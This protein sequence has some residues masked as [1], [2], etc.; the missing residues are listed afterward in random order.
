M[1]HFGTAFEQAMEDSPGHPWQSPPVGIS[2]SIK[3]N[4][5]GV[6]GS[7]LASAGTTAP[8]VRHQDRLCIATF[9]RVIPEAQRRNYALP[10]LCVTPEELANAENEVPSED[11]PSEEKESEQ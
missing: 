4:L 10:G 2:S 3:A 8:S 6:L 5:R 7:A 11:A 1:V 9:H